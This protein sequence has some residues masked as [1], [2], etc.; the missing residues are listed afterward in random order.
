[1]SR[2]FF[3]LVPI[4]MCVLAR[5]G[6]FYVSTQGNDG[7]PGSVDRPWRSMQKAA[8][9]LAPGDTV[10]VRAG[11]YHESVQVNVSG[12]VAGGY[13]TFA[14]FPNEKPVVD[15]S[16]LTPP[17][18][19]SAL[20][21]LNDRGFVAITGFE[22]CNYRATNGEKVPCGIFVTGASHDIQIISNDVHDIEYDTATGNAFGIAFYGTSRTLPI[23]NVVVD[24]NDVHDLKTGNS[25]SL[26][27]NG[28]VKTFQVT[29][30]RVHDNNNIGID[31]IG[32]E[33]TCPDPL[34]DQA[35]DGVCQG[36]VIWNISSATNPAY[37]GDTSATGIYC[38]GAARVVI[39]RNMISFC[40]YGAELAS[41]HRGRTARD[42]LFRDNFVFWC[43]HPGLSLGGY[44][45]SST[46]GALRCVVTNNTF[47]QNNTSEEGDGE[48]LFQYRVLKCSVKN[49]IL[50]AGESG[51]LIANWTGAR[52]T[53]GTVL[54]YN[55]YF[56]PL[57]ENSSAW[58]W[59]NR[60]GNSLASW[61][62]ASRQDAHALFV[63]PKLLNT[64]APDLHLQAGS[65]ARDAADPGFVPP[66]G[67]T[68]ID[69]EARRRGAA[70]DIGADEL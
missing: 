9:T 41:E 37:A 5:A 28:N 65:P 52:N 24:G 19:A 60:E 57:G 49:N 61:K 33:G 13:V 25:E 36:N 64:N 39:E 10:F 55:L 51:L 7:N 21:F 8:N 18:D 40:D 48:I 1:M 23:R 15:G 70:T 44:D 27:L 32:F 3:F 30:N 53:T 26:T 34:Q 17:T 16:T 35:R 4:L 29:N 14:N 46:G 31:F 62:T 11:V 2:L 43:R 58:V 56:S 6:E 20:F 59:K 50:F 42:C 67:E 45:S 66:P 63:D 12:S 38:D 47:F 68:D 69:G 54:D 22:I